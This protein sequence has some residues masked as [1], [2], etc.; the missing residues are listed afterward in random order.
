MS[1]DHPVRRVD[2]V[3]TSL[4]GHRP[5]YLRLCL[6]H[7]RSAGMD[8]VVHAPGSPAA[9]PTH[10][11]DLLDLAEWQF[12]SQPLSIDE[13]SNL[14]GDRIVVLDGDQLARSSFR[15]GR[16]PTHRPILAL[17][18][19]GQTPTLQRDLRRTIKGIGRYAVA[20]RLGLRR[21]V[22]VLTLAS[23]SE[24]IDN[25]NV[26]DPVPIN[27]DAEDVATFRDRWLPPT[28]DGDQRYWI[29]LLGVINHRKN[30]SMVVDALIEASGFLP[31]PALLLAGP[32]SE[33]YR[34]EV[35]AAVSRLERVG[36]E[37]V[38]L[39]ESL[40]DRTFDAAIGAVDTV[41]VAYDNDGPSGILGKA[42]CLGTRV[43]AAGSQALKR[44]VEALNL[45]SWG[46]LDVAGIRQ[47][48]VDTH[49][50]PAPAPITDLD[51]SAFAKRM[52][53]PEPQR[54]L[55]WPAFRHRA[56]NPY[57]AELADGLVRTGRKVNEF[58]PNRELLRQQDVVLVHWPE[59]APTHRS[60]TVRWLA[61]VGVLWV[62]ILHQRLGKASLV[63]V[64]HNVVP[65][66]NPSPRLQRWFM[67]RLTGILDG[68]ITLSETSL[69]SVAEQYPATADVHQLVVRHP[70]YRATHT[71][72]D[73][74][75]G[76]LSQRLSEI[77]TDTTVL[78]AWG[79]IETYKQI[80]QL[81]EQALQLDPG[82]LT[83]VAG[84]CS[85]QAVA[86][87]L[88]EQQRRHP[89]RLL[90]AI[91]H[92]EPAELQSLLERANAAVFN[93]ST[94]TNSGS[95]IASLS[96]GVPVIA[97]RH[98][99]LEELQLELGDDWV[100]LFEP[101]LQVASLQKLMDWTPPTGPPIT[102]QAARQWPTV[103]DQTTQMLDRLRTTG[104]D[105][106]TQGSSGSQP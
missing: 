25:S 36:I 72:T 44:D 82:V 50:A 1:T 78:A 84:H 5:L 63:W 92:L 85:D 8:C 95:V 48:L 69:R 30:V 19:R 89:D 41:V 55:A 105:M 53:D 43:T 54:I 66:R 9:L 83:V 90:V 76:A 13:V 93:F 7:A 11:H 31:R 47:A 64:V 79:K 34:P 27:A 81:V 87:R 28:P 18:L 35:K 49:A 91:G 24:A 88:R 77:P 22:T 97:P 2:L 62:L 73:V 102:E 96:A 70:V 10:Q 17:S 71:N 12:T 100:R 26:R 3:V 6:E 59:F 52:L 45:G 60:L 16:V 20:R 23:A 86:A 29:G 61:S 67:R 15:Q 94:I 38:L 104:R 99:G 14:D 80:E 65:H 32:I 51:S 75:R 39:E 68:I 98:P 40:D 103:I 106:T 101:P 74:A 46:P 58:G 56:G 4:E 21:D 57:T 42:A 37:V 33:D